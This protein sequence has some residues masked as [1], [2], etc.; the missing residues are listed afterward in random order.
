MQDR[1][2]L[3][4]LVL[5][6]DAA[7]LARDVVVD[8]PGAQR[9]GPVE[10]VQGDE[11]VE[12]LRLGLAQR[13]AHAR[14]LELEDAGGAAVAEELI[15]LADALLG[16]VAVGVLE[17]SGSASSS[18]V[19]PSVRFSS[20]RASSSSVSVLRPE[21][22]HLQETD[23]L[24]LLHRPLGRD[25]V[26]L[27]LVERGELG[28]RPRR[29]HDAG[30]VHRR[31]PRH[32]LER[33]PMSRQ[34]LHLRVAALQLLEAR[35]LLERLVERHVERRRDQLGDLVDVGERH[36]EHAPDVAHHGLRLHRP[37]GDDLGDVL[38]AVLAR[39]VVDDLAAAALAEVDV[40]VGQRDALGVEEALE[41]QVELDR[42]DVGDL[43][44]PGDDRAGG[45]AAA[46]ADRDAG[47]A[48]EADEVPD[49][50]EVPGYFICLIIAT[51]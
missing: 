35:A 2:E 18:M 7:V 29:N 50:Q 12:A 19:S 30:G 37:E 28:D 40:D 31:V 20:A 13:L 26:L 27:A 1:L 48:R 11:V 6:V 9:A 44:A 51:S 36:V 49:D 42:V 33:R 47:F 34:L 14:A 17:F 21:E 22:V 24:D 15:R 16:L 23:A 32:P 4:V 45:G 10:R 8:D 3:L 43:Q 38:A 39:D 46:R 5:D 41:E 25:F